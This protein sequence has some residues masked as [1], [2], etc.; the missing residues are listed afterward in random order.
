[1]KFKIALKKKFSNKTKEKRKKKYIKYKSTK[2][3]ESIT[4]SKKK[5]KF[6]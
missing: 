2:Y 6:A 3:D 4:I 5:K 1:M